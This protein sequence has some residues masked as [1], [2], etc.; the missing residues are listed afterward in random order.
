MPD[1]IKRYGDLNT[2]F[3]ESLLGYNTRRASYTIL[4]VFFERMAAYGLRPVD[5]SLLCLI[6]YNPGIT[7]RRLSEAL[8][9]QPPNLVGKV[10]AMLK[11]GWIDRK[12]DALDKRALGLTITE[13]GLQLVLEAEKTAQELEIEA[14]SQLTPEERATLIELL[15]KVYLPT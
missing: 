13:A 14:S 9:I 10:A 4:S 7:S 6:H 2:E 3:L 15:K 5:F 1:K 11:S 8:A 12:A